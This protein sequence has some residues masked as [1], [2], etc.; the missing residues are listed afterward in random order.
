MGAVMH[1]T[2]RGPKE[3]V[4]GSSIVIRSLSYGDA[5]ANVYGQPYK[6]NHITNGFAREVGV[7]LAPCDLRKSMMKNIPS[8]STVEFI[9]FRRRY[10]PGV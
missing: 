7:Y 8:F 9:S 10:I 3:I 2:T 5:L 1:H 4:T 6:H